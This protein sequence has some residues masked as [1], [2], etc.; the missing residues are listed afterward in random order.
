MAV[1]S[2]VCRT[3]QL[4]R[5]AM[6]QAA[7]AAW[8]CILFGN[9]VVAGP[10]VW[11]QPESS[12]AESSPPDAGRQVDTASN[13]AAGSNIVKDTVTA[14]R[15]AADAANDSVLAALATGNQDIT[16]GAVKMGRVKEFEYENKIVLE[17][18][19]NEYFASQAQKWSFNVGGSGTAA[20][21]LFP[22]KVP[23]AI[24]YYHVKASF[25]WAVPQDTSVVTV[26]LTGINELRVGAPFTI[27]GMP[28][29]YI[30]TFG[31]GLDNSVLAYATT[32]GNIRGGAEDYYFNY[33]LG[34]IIR[35]PFHVMNLFYSLGLNLDFE[36]AF[37]CNDDTMQRIAVSILLGV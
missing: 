30:P 34:L 36:R 13:P 22:I 2:A 26:L 32:V 23:F 14:A 29:E 35:Q 18:G 19:L 25:H 6:K 16:H 5:V 3:M 9:F 24:L 21:L 7:V 27:Q 8:L 4:G 28:F 17:V 10:N 37:N 12:H 1:M 33:T 11:C 31:I 20:G 15:A